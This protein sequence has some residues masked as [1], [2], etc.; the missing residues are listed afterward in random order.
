MI[1]RRITAVSLA[2]LLALAPIASAFAQGPGPQAVIQQSWRTYKAAATFA[3]AT[4][5][6]AD[7]F[8]ITGSATAN[9][10][11][12][13]SRIACFGTS[14]AAA[15]IPISV[16]KRSAIPTVAGTSTSPTAIPVDTAFGQAAGATVR[17]YT[18]APTPGAAVGTMSI[19]P[20]FS[21]PVGTPALTTIVDFEFNNRAGESQ[22]TMLRSATQ[23]LALNATMVA[24]QSVTCE[25]TW[26]EQP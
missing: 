12:R 19:R 7:F 4:T 9:A 11:V 2:A 15:L 14:T 20:M 25:V 8:T 10:F 16:I 18:V 17:A 24:G 23:V 13:V 1:L 3:P 21:T 22:G 5:A 26:M 6:T